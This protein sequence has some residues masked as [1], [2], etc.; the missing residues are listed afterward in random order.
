[1]IL[2]NFSKFIYIKIVSTLIFTDTISSRI[3]R[4]PYLYP[5]RQNH[6]QYFVDEKKRDVDGKCFRYSMIENIDGILISSDRF[7]LRILLQWIFSWI[8]NAFDRIRRIT[9]YYP[10][11]SYNFVAFDDPE[12]DQKGNFEQITIHITLIGRKIR[13][14]RAHDDSNFKF[15]SNFVQV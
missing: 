1:M 4:S 11:R 10:Q 2:R 9:Y 7:T 5:Y 13:L 3:K 6:Y 12:D 15:P 8:E 14:W